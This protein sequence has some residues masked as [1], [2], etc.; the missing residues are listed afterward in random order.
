MRWLATWPLKLGIGLVLSTISGQVLAFNLIITEREFLQLSRNCQLYY[1][2]AVGKRLP[3][4]PPFSQSDVNAARV[5]A[6]YIGGAW[7]YCGGL[8]WLNRALVAP[9]ER[10][11][12]TAYQQALL[13]INFTASKTPVGNPMYTEIK[14]NQA[15]AYYYNGQ[16]DRSKNLL[17][18]L[19]AEFPTM[20]LARIELAR[21]HR[22]EKK[23]AQAIQ[24]LEKASEK[25][26]AVSA[27]LNY[28]LGVYHYHEGNFAAAKKYG[29]QAYK[30]G[31]PLPWL[32]NKLAAKGLK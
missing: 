27:D 32:K 26:F 23:T 8:V 19:L 29:D 11:K 1:Y 3:F 12:K 20:T 16:R 28:F 5:D 18:S 15:K 31:Y 30:L 10:S 22:L 17:N 21:Q 7:H 9:D 25:E 6:E 2:S 24:I 13:E 4:D 14:V